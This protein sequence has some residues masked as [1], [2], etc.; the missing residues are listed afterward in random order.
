MVKMPG[1]GR[2][3]NLLCQIICGH[4]AQ[5]IFQHGRHITI[6]QTTGIAKRP[7]AQL[8]QHDKAAASQRPAVI[9]PGSPAGKNLLAVLTRLNR[10]TALRERFLFI[11]GTLVEMCG[12]LLVLLQQSGRLREAWIHLLAQGYQPVGHTG[13]RKV[14]GVEHTGKFLRQTQPQCCIFVEHS[15][16]CPRPQPGLRNDLL[17]QTLTK[18]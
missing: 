8:F 13:Q 10:K 12:E 17:R 18:L 15:R 4:A 11:G 16:H 3:I 14:S 5:V 7:P 9:L 6:R 1:G 2:S